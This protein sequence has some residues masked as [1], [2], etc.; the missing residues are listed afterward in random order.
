MANTF[1][2]NDKVAVISTWNNKGTFSIRRATVTAWG[3]Q[4][5]RLMDEKGTMF[6]VAFH[7]DYI[8]N[9]EIAI[10]ADSCNDDLV[11]IAEEMAIAYLDN[12]HVVLNRHKSLS[13]NAN[14]RD[15]MDREIADLH[16][17]RIHW[18]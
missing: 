11:V 9:L 14:Y 4:V 5:I 16:E 13:A 8:N 3:K 2:K 7:P 6:K 15:A 18:R 1:K 12:R 17:P 10:V